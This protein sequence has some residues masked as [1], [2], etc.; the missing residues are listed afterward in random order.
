MQLLGGKYKK[1]SH[2][3]KNSGLHNKS[4]K[5]GSNTLFSIKLKQSFQEQILNKK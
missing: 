4:P 2:K 3:L 1:I 5:R